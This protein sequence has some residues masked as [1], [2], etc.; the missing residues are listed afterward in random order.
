MG[1]CG[2]WEQH[3]DGMGVAKFVCVLGYGKQRERERGVFLL[4][5]DEVSEKSTTPAHFFARTGIFFCRCLLE[6][7]LCFLLF[8]LSMW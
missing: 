8:S 7:L 5:A 1:A 2:F 6:I 3:G 4:V